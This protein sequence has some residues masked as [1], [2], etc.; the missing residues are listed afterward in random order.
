MM[1]TNMDTD[2]NT[3]MEMEMEM[4]MD[5]EIDTSATTTVTHIPY[6]KMENG[7]LK[8]AGDA[9]STK[10]GFIAKPTEKQLL[11]NHYYP[12]NLNWTPT[13]TPPEGK[14]W[15]RTVRMLFHEGEIPSE[16]YFYPEHVLSDIPT[17]A[18]RTFSKMYLEDELFKRGLLDTVDAFIDSQEISN[19]F[20]QKMPLRRKYDTAL[21]F[22]EDH[23]SFVQ[24]YTAIKTML[25]LTD[26]DAE[27]ILSNSVSV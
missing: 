10:S 8:Y 3:D 25:G 12:V 9:I 18:P 16:S 11:E 5:N 6:A 22:S 15:T 13:E 24:F 23:P 14:R 21:V 26:E 1:E 4:E 2:T 27:E 17:P 20:G 7:Q 19:D